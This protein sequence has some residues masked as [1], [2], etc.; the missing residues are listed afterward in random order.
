[1][2]RA[3]QHFEA[4]RLNTKSRFDRELIERRLSKCL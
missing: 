3:R 1:M 2:V 4:A